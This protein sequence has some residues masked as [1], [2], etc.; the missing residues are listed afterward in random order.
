MPSLNRISVEKGTSVGGKL[1]PAELEVMPPRITIETWFTRFAAGAGTLFEWRLE[2]GCIV[3][4]LA[5]DPNA[6]ILREEYGIESIQFLMCPITAQATLE[7]GKVYLAEKYAEAAKRQGLGGFDGDAIGYAADHI[8]F[9]REEAVL[10]AP[11]RERLLRICHL[12]EEV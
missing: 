1:V 10:Y 12:Q 11:I 8:G 2:G 3:A 6:E 4:R 7:E 9:D 5:V